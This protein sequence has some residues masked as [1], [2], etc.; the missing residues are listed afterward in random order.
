MTDAELAAI[1]RRLGEALIEYAYSRRD[2]QKKL[3]AEIHTELC[4]K[5]RQEAA[6]KQ[7]AG[8]PPS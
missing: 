8:A 2:D 1:A 6:E 7:D 4:T 5:L 3:I